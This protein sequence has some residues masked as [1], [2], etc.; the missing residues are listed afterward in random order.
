MTKTE[1]NNTRR[2][3]YMVCQYCGKEMTGR[4]RN[5]CDIECGRNAYKKKFKDQREQKKVTK[6]CRECGKEFV[7]MMPW[8]KFCCDRC[9]DKYKRQHPNYPS[10]ICK[11]CGK[12]YVPKSKERT[13]YCSRECAFE[14]MAAKPKD[15]G[16]VINH[17]ACGEIITPKHKYC[18][19]C[20]KERARYDS[21]LRKTAKE[22]KCRWCD[23][24]FTP[25]YKA[26]T[27]VYCCEEHMVLAKK[28]RDKNSLNRKMHKGGVSKAKRN[29]I[30]FR[31]GFKCKLCGKKMRMDKAET[32]W[33]G[34]PHPLAP[35]VDHIIP[36]SIAKELGW[37]KQEMNAERNLQAAHFSCNVNKGNR[38]SNDQLRLFG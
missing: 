29:R 26:K 38:A 14:H 17:C 13:T 24:T 27:Y 10:C 6:A 4:K 25:E 32:V 37:T 15:P 19:E 34:N 31:D 20:R 2:G 16:V 35:T 7:P 21:Y 30:Y 33:L 18:D 9:R 36:K 5:Y 1:K 28:E 23:K 8:G 12:E 3:V 11:H 22:T